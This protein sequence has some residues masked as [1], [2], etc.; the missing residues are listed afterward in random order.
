MPNNLEEASA[1]TKE[2]FDEQVSL[3]DLPT[4]EEIEQQEESVAATDENEPIEEDTPI[5]SNTGEDIPTETGVAQA[6]ID[7]AAQTA[8]YAAQ[9]AHDKNGQLQQAL[10]DI[11]NLKQQNQQLQGTIE[12]LSKKNV[13]NIIEDAITPPTLDINGLAFA[14]ESEQQAAL[15]KYARDMSEYNRQ[16]IMQEMSPAIEFAKKGMREAEKAETVDI[17]A[18]IPELSNIK[19]LLPQLDRLIDNNKWLSSDDMPLDEKY[20]NAFAMLAGLNSINNPAEPAKEP[21]AE[22][23]LEIYKSNPAFQELVEK[24]RIESIKDSQQ[25]PPFSASSGAVNAALD[26]KEKPKTLAEASKRTLEDFISRFN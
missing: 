25:V 26:I 18:K 14:D 19:E 12:E 17:L 20:I 9:V 8:E 21:T 7:E 11:E 4:D 10:Q 3:D 5:N 23:L 13:D 16:Q 1:A 22:E 6:D 24:E 15:A 2:L